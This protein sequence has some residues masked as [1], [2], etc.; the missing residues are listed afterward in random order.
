[1]FFLKYIHKTMVLLINSIYYLFKVN[2]IVLNAY[3]TIKRGKI[4]HR[5]W[6]DD[7]NI[8]LI[9]YLT[10]RPVIVANQSLI[11]RIIKLNKFVCIGSTLNLYS[12]SKTE[13]W[14]TGF[15]DV[16]DSIPN[17]PYKIHSVRGY[18]TYYKLMSRGIKCPKSFGDPVLL[19]SKVYTPKKIGEFKLGIIPHGVDKNNPLLLAFAKKYRDQVLII[20]LVN[21]KKWTDILDSIISCRLILSSSLHGLIASDSYN[22]PNFWIRLSSGLIGGDFKFLDYFSSVQRKVNVINIVSLDILETFLNNQ[23]NYSYCKPIIDFKS[24]EESCPF[25]IKLLT[26]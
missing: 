2:P 14:G 17:V 1:M 18:L 7:L 8:Y 4:I 24:I 9:E 15:I 10:Q 19:V 25:D 11:H 23:E 3:V 16:N 22:I 21:Y 26:N 12:D 20:D 13:V 5:N 6:G